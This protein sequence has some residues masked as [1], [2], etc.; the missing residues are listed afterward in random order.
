MLKNNIKKGITLIALVATITVTIILATTA[1][2]S[3]SSFSVSAKKRAFANEI[4]TLQKQIENYNFKNNKYPI[5]QK[6]QI[7]SG[8]VD[9][10]LYSIFQTNNE[11]NDLYYI[12]YPKLDL[13]NLS[14]GL[15]ESSNDIYLFSSL[16]KKVYY[17]AGEKI[18][19]E[20]YYYLTEN[21]YDSLK[22]K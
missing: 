18:G 3:Y 21:L 1:V 20:K 6:K 5:K 19:N 2:V 4:Y 14:R 8:S 7:E 15:D 16:T 9:N 11:L 10:A 13:D 22:M 12:D 17:L